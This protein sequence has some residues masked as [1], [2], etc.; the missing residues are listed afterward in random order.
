M[1]L[2]IFTF[3]A[4][5]SFGGAQSTTVQYNRGGAGRPQSAR[6]PSTL[7]ARM[8]TKATVIRPVPSARQAVGDRGQALVPIGRHGPIRSAG[9]TTNPI[10]DHREF[11]AAFKSTGHATSR[12]DSCIAD[13]AQSKNRPGRFEQLNAGAPLEDDVQGKV[14]Y[15]ALGTA[16]YG[17][18][19][20][21]MSARRMPGFA[22]LC[23]EDNIPRP[24]STLARDRDFDLED[25]Q[26]G[27]Q[28]I[29]RQADKV[30]L[31]NVLARAGI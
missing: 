14:V 22:D 2:K 18:V 28:A 7:G 27:L 12:G 20:R 8:D 5:M 26:H 3:I 21:P 4:T 9:I 31:D 15:G 6:A 19:E 13:F 30:K 25:R 23:R 17:R 24:P 11:K 29:L 16:Q 1:R 10:G